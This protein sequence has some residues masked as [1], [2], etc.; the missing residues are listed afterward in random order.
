MGVLVPMLI[1]IPLWK[2]RF[3]ALLPLVMV[4]P[5]AA[6]LAGG[7]VGHIVVM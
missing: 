1:F 6:I 2:H 5:W 7:N 3:T 4:F